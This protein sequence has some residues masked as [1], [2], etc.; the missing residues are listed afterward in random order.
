MLD[1]HG[2]KR[3]RAT[4]EPLLLVHTEYIEVHRCSVVAMLLQPRHQGSTVVIQMELHL[5][6][7]HQSITQATLRQA[8]ARPREFF[9]SLFGQVHPA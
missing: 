1:L 2:V 3:R 7:E 9:R 4:V 5:R 8:K 6:H